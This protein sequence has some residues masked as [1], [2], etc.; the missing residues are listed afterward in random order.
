MKR[1]SFYCCLLAALLGGVIAAGCGAAG[2]EAVHDAGSCSAA[3]AALLAGATDD[4][5][6]LAALLRAEGELV[7]A[8]QIDTLMALWAAEGE[9]VD[10]K[11]TP[12]DP[13]DDQ[14]WMGADAVRHRYV[15]TV[16]PGAPAAADPNAPAPELAIR[17]DGARA[18]VRATTRIGDEV[19]AAGDQWTFVRD[20]ACWL[21]ESLTYNLEAA[22]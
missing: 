7:V 1:P 20:G 5:A 21:I 10:A 16:F 2:E 4:D 13:A 14:R 8:Q 6:Q 12:A 9:V 22:P 17:Y 15:R 3:V 11:H 18:T 19:A